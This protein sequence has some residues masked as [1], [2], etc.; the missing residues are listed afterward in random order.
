MKCEKCKS[1]VKNITEMTIYF[2][3]SNPDKVEITCKNGYQGLSMKDIMDNRK[4][5]HD[6]LD[7]TLDRISTELFSNQVEKRKKEA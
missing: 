2:D 1:N 3:A 5:L 4:S 7:K 6:C